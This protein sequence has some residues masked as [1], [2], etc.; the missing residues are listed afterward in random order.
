MVRLFTTRMAFKSLPEN[1]D[2]KKELQEIVAGSQKTA[3]KTNG[4]GGDCAHYIKTPFI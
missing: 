4:S 3:A 1:Q 2:F